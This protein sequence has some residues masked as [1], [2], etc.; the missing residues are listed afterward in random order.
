MEQQE[1]FSATCP[2]G[3]VN[4]A[5]YISAERGAMAKQAEPVQLFC[6]FRGEH[7]TPAEDVQV[8]IRPWARGANSRSLDGPSKPTAHH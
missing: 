8:S 5:V 4:V 3:R 7:W 2:A 6:F 1:G